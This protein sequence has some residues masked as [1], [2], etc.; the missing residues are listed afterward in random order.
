MA[1][2]QRRSLL[3]TKIILDEEKILRE[4]KYNL[5]QMY[6]II[7][8]MA[9]ESG[10]V[11]INKHTYHCKGNEKDLACLGIFI[12]YNLMEAEWFVK[13]VAE[14]IWI[15]EREG[16]LDIIATERAKNN[17]IGSVV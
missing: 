3:G 8:E 14:W 6:E 7:D 15:S 4:K 12:Q 11:K 9:L 2:T 1:T 16:D 13:N 17:Y 5:A 10:L